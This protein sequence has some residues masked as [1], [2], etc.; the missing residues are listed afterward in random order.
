MYKIGYNVDTATTAELNLFMWMYSPILHK[1]GWKCLILQHFMAFL[2]YTDV[3]K[4]NVLR[5]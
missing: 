5:R 2:E 3:K 1:F 4:N